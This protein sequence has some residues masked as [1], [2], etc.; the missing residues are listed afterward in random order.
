MILL[1]ACVDKS[2]CEMEGDAVTLRPRFS[3]LEDVVNPRVASLESNIALFFGGYCRW[4][5]ESV[6]LDRQSDGICCP[7]G[8][9]LEEKENTPCPRCTL[10]R[11]LP[12]L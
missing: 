10:C 12:E 8:Y 1:A 6:L 2:S 5:T 9:F 7:Y 3:S 11:D 4:M